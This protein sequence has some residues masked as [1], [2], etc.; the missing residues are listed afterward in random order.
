MGKT[1]LQ[2]YKNLGI[3]AFK[4]KEFD[5]AKTF[6]SLAYKKRI[7]KKLLHFI[8]LCDFAKEQE[9]RAFL[10]FDFY[11]KHYKSAKIYKEFEQI[12]FITETKASLEQRLYESEDLG[13]SYKDFLCSEKVVG[14]QKSFE[15]IIFSNKLIINVKA[16]F[17]NFLEKLLENGY[18]E[19]ILN[20][21]ERLSLYFLEDEKF[22]ALVRKINKKERQGR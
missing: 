19:L 3:Q 22:E 17:L 14:F 5:L 7:N 16:D 6:F 18:K 20:H 15:N 8:N 1:N 21:I 11:I 4:R 13:F 9:Q 12:F 10:L 2:N